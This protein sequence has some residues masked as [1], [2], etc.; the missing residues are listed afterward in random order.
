MIEIYTDGA[1][2][3]NGYEDSVG[4]WAYILVHNGQIFKRESGT[5]KPATNNQC[6]LMAMIE[7]CKM[8][9]TLRIGEKFT[10]Y[11][12][13]AYCINCYKEKWYKKWKIN[14]WKNSKNQPVSNQDLWEE[15][16]PYFE[17][18]DFNFKKIKGHSINRFN[19]IVDKMAVEA[20]N[21]KCDNSSV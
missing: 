15:L 21:V 18:E 2:S 16:I 3:S 19:N 9:L 4:G 1:T 10:L 8:A 11:S 5:V 14:G 6:E 20:K 12:D 17:S 7:A 13:S